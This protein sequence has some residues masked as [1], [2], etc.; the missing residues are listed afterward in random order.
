MLTEIGQK[1]KETSYVLGKMG[2]NLKNAGLLAAAQEIL[3]EENEILRANAADVARA[4]ERGMAPGLVDRLE[5]NHK[6]IEGIVEG[7]RQVVGLDD[8]VGEVISMKKRPNGLLIGQKRVPLGVIG[9][10]Y[11]A[12]PNVTADAFALCFKAG[13]AVILRGGSDALES[14]KAIVAAIRNGLKKEN[15]PEDAIALIEDTSHETAREFMRMNG[16]LDVLIPRGGAGLIRTVVENST[17][18]VIE[19]GTGNCHVYVDASADIDMAVKIILNAKTQRTGVCNA[20][21]SLVIHK[22]IIEEA[23]PAIA[24]A[25]RE[26]HCELRGDE[27]ALE[28]VP[29]MKKATEEDWGTEYLDLIA[30]VRTV[31]SVD[32]A[33]EHINRYNTG[34]SE[35]IVT[36][37]YA[38]ARKFLDEV[39]AAAV[40]VNAST[41]FTDG[42]EFGFGAEIGISTQKLHARGPMGLK[43]LT[44][45]KYV[46]YGDGQIRE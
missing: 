27:A 28:V 14:N 39:D 8:P 35:A 23:L 33:I 5:L 19:T 24:K 40:Y 4:K 30:S 29:D 7:M 11:E 6:R 3:D 43:E 12:R 38:N 13:N 41:R 1:A 17:V 25:L 16:Y 45:T 18:P 46:I 37:D 34:H 15:I 9:I 32:E 2:T 36:K 22:D 21:E 44:T 42:F 26:R 10:I 20:C 31:A